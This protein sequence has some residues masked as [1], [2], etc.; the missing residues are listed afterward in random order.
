MTGT[1][2]LALLGRIAESDNI[3]AVWDLATGYFAGLGF[4]RANYGFTRFQTRQDH[5]RPG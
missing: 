5:R 2:V 3:D 4:A 1:P